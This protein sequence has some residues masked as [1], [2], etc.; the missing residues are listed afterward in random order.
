MRIWLDGTPVAAGSGGIK[1]YTEELREALE[2]CFPEHEFALAMPKPGRWWS[3]RLPLALKSAKVS[4]FH[5]TDFAVPYWQVCPSVMTIHDLS[6]W[7]REPWNEASARVRKRTPWLVR[8]KRATMIVAPTEA[9]RREVVE[10]F[11]IRPDRVAAVHLAA[12]SRFQPGAAPQP[13]GRYFLC[14][15]AGTR[16]NFAMVQALGA[17]LG[18]EVR[19]TG[20]GIPEDDLPAAYAGALATLVPSFYEGFGLPVLEAMQCGTP[21]IASRDAAL[22]EVSGGAAWHVDAGDE[23][24]WLEAMSAISSDDARR[25]EMGA[26]GLR[27][28]RAF[29]WERTARGTWD[30]YMEAMRRHVR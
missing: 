18:I 26:A 25:K 1:R 14:A 20:G 10:Y 17:Q 3:A 28:A 2:A 29:S 16:K 30:V 8:L 13:A 12:S 21:V 27:R 23:R 4:L 15:G 11:R 9:V 24:A 19:V 22:R 5:G 7:K 6:P